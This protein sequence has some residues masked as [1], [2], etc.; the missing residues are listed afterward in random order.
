MNMTENEIKTVFTELAAAFC[1]FPENLRVTVTMTGHSVCVCYA[2]HADDVRKLVGKQG[3]MHRALE[4]VLR[5]VA[6]KR[7]LRA[8]LI[9]DEPYCGQALPASP[10]E[11]NRNWQPTKVVELFKRL[12]PLLFKLQVAPEFQNNSSD[13]STMLCRVDGDDRWPSA[14]GQIGD[15][16]LAESLS[17]IFDSIGRADGRKIYVELDRTAA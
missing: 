16:E 10:F 8:R 5:A 9:V 4:T 14:T 17:R 15:D 1:R 12:S 2:S 11:R 6:G 13:S 3:A 7:Q